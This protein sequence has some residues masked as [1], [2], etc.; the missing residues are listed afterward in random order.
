MV[1]ISWHA[2]G[3]SALLLEVDSLA[4]AH[5]IWA[6]LRAADLPGVLDLVVGAST[7]LV[8]VDP[9]SCDPE[10]VVRAA[11]AAGAAPVAEPR[12]VEIPVVYD[13]ADL[14]DVAG[15]AGMSIEDVVRVHSESAYLVAFLGFAPG[16]GYL[17]GLDPRLRLPRRDSPRT[18]VPAGSVAIAGEYTAVYPK[19]TPGGWHLLGRTEVS[20]FDPGAVRPALLGPG[21]RVRFVPAGEFR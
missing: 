11:A 7:V 5:R 20:V 16:F 4:T 14:A 3:E 1:D 6:G 8:T 15:R 18:R 19:P 12:T 13:G 2:A 9:L 17:T 21:D 10:G